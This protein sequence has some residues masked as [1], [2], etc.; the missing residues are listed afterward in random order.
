MRNPLSAAVL[1][2]AGCGAETPPPSPS[3]APATGAYPLKTCVV[4]DE[5]LG[6]MGE[7]VVFTHEGVEVR[8]CCPACRKEFDRDPAKFVAKL[9]AAKR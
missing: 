9:N 5:D 6:S 7:P 4:S 2:L 3:P 8:L 1:L